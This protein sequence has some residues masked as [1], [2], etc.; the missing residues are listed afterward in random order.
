MKW[1]QKSRQLIREE[2]E[3]NPTL[4]RFGSGWISGVIGM[5]L[6]MSTD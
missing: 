1:I 3:C 6:G 5:M 2:L 4:R